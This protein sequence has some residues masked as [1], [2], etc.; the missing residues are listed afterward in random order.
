MRRTFV[1]VGASIAGASAAA[2]LRDEGFDGRILLVGAEPHLPYDRP[3][4]SKG[5]LTGSFPADKLLLRPPGFWDEQEIELLLGRPVVALHPRERAI[6][7]AGGERLA[8]DGLLLAT[9]G[10]NRRLPVPGADL[11]GSYGLRTRDDADRI[12]AAIS[13]AR[14]AVVVGMG[15]IGS[16]IAASLRTLGLEVV[17]IEPQ[18]APLERVLGVEVGRVIAELHAE[19]GVELLLGEGVAAFEGDDR[20]RQVRTSTG[21]LVECDLAVVGVGIAPATELAEAAGLAVDDGIL[22]DERCRTGAEGVFAAGDV[23]RHDHPLHGRRIRVEHWQN[24][25]E[26]GAAAARSMLARSEPY[27]ELHWF[28]SDQYDANLQYLGHHTR[29]DELV[30]RGSLEERRFV[31]FY[32]ENGVPLAAVGLNAGR[33]LRR[34]AGLI[35]A[36]QAV[37]RALLRDPEID[38]RTLA[39]S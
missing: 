5:Y 3:P 17:A 29:F 8:Y 23:A 16:E 32:L 26:Q 6:E 25:V 11:P 10:R 7:L 31:A 19:H 18:R 9:G 28:W 22:V 13:Q 20:L 21:R 2:T 33:D 4:L 30:V 15:F 36:R 38:L 27:A 14:R 1:I 35:R 39:R 37:D 12:R 24:A 34:A